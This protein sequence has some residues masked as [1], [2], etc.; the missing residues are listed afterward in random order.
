MDGVFLVLALAI[1]VSG[2]VAFLLALAA[3][4]RLSVAERRIAALEAELRAA[5]LREA[6]RLPGAPPSPVIPDPLRGAEEGPTFA[7]ATEVAAERK[8]RPAD[9]PPPPPFFPPPPIEAPARSLEERLGAHWTV[10]VGG[11]ALALGGL[12]LVRYSIEQ[13]Y[14]GPAARC[15]L[16]LAFGVALAVAGEFL[17]GREKAGGSPT[18]TPAILTAAGT[19]A[20]FGAIYAAHGLYGLIGPSV[21]FV[22]LGAIALAAILAAVL[23]GPSLAGLGLVGAG[24][25]PLLVASPDP[26]PWPVVL[27]LAIVAGAAH[28]LARLRRWLWL[29]CAAAGVG[30]LWAVVFA[31]EDSLDFF[32]AGLVQALVSA[33]LAAVFVALLPHAGTRDEDVSIDPVA[34]AVV[35]VFAAVGCLVLATASIHGPFDLPIVFLA[36]ALVAGLAATGARIAPVAGLAL[37]AGALALV[38]LHLWPGDDQRTAH[39]SMLLTLYE[40]L[41][42]TRFM[43]FA[44]VGAMIVAGLGAGRLAVGRALPPSPASLYAIGAAVTPLAILGLAYLRLARGETGM[45]FAIVAGLLA[46][47]FALQ[48]QYFRRGDE[49]GAFNATRLALGAFATASLAAL[50]L[51]LVFVLDRG[52]LTVALALAALAAAAISARLDI[53]ALRWASAAMGLVVLARLIW[54]PRIVGGDLGTTPILNWLLFGYGVPALAFGFAARLMRRA[55]GEDPPV[56]VAQS[57]SILFA[58]FLVFFEIRHALNGGEPYARSSR[59]IEQ[60]LFA[61]AAL[62]FSLTLTRLDAARSSRVFRV[63]SFVFGAI[64]VGVAALGLVAY[65]NPYLSCRPIEGGAVFNGLLLGYAA[66]AIV[67]AM[68]MVAARGVRPAWFTTGTGALSIALLFLYACLETRRLFHDS[69]ICSTRGQG[70]MEIWAYSAVWL[71]LGVLLLFYGIAR[72]ARGA[73][74]ASAIFV[75]AA[76][77][78]IFLYDLSDLEGLMRALSFIGLGVVLIGIGLVYQ[79]LVF[80]GPAQ[81]VTGAAP[82]SSGRNG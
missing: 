48:A 26:N 59:L 25:A 30:A 61:T 24:V 9:L 67:A 57:L 2:P 27:Y 52:M 4:A 81:P 77:L 8:H 20:A 34:T 28:T 33:T 41:E 69:D 32:H 73:R 78:K 37:I 11:V 75:L 21:A 1:A 19:V 68:L 12:L 79:K 74:F 60:G 10:L 64:S 35:G 62:L 50:A 53:G 13:G 63:A 43:I 65:A 40:P 72:R 42:P 45:A 44:A 76:V 39:L 15:A 5:G 80:R 71:G 38:V 3:R 23:H 18:Q 49:A 6:A 82:E 51:G 70:D 22:A 55:G 66:P 31:L 7:E 36:G 58:A 47:G 17:R 29:A 54:E 46:T 14:F 56:R 16:G